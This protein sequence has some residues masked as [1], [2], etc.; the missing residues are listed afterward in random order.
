ME[1][2]RAR[3]EGGLDTVPSLSG[4]LPG[5]APVR[6][7]LPASGRLLKWQLVPGG[8]E[9]DFERSVLEIESILAPQPIQGIFQGMVPGMFTHCRLRYT[10]ADQWFIHVQ[11]SPN[12]CLF[13]R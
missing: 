6:L 9:Y 8:L 3:G 2:F 11:A 12:L 5:G 13:F 4:A 10:N 7:K 1:P